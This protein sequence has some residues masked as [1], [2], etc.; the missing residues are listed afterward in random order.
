M[1]NPAAF[2][3]TKRSLTIPGSPGI[4]RG[5]R[6]YERNRDKGAISVSALRYR[7]GNW[8]A[9]C[10]HF[11][12]RFLPTNG[13]AVSARRVYEGQFEDMDAPAASLGRNPERYESW[14]LPLE[15][16]RTEE[17]EVKVYHRGQVVKVTRQYYTVG[18][19]GYGGLRQAA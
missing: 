5:R 15:L 1:E 2:A 16:E 19:K 3:A 9:V 4:A 14:D 7:F 17:K 13:Q 8:E 12:V 18:P 10:Q 11:G 6:D